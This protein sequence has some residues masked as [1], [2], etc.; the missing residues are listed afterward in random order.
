MLL[1]AQLAFF[2]VMALKMCAA[3][4]RWTPPHE[5]RKLLGVLCGA[6]N[7][8]SEHGIALSRQGGDFVQ[9]LG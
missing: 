3:A 8:F 6:K 1:A 5:T 2:C 7:N 4:H 9:D